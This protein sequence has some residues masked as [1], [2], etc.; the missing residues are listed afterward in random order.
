MTD[1]SFGSS[2]IGVSQLRRS[3]VV[4]PKLRV[5]LPAFT[6]RLHEP[7]CEQA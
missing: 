7:N 1:G 5:E 6:E 4:A 2:T 3:A